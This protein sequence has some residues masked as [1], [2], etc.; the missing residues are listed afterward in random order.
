ME[1]CRLHPTAGRHFVHVFPSDPF[2][3]EIRDCYRSAARR[4]PW[5]SVDDISYWHPDRPEWGDRERVVIF[6][7]ASPG[8]IPRH[9]RAAAVLRYTE[10]VGIPEGL[11]PVQRQLVEQFSA[12]SE[13]FDMLLG[14]TVTVADFWSGK[15]KM[16]AFA[17]IGYEPEI[18]GR[19]DWSTPKIAD[20][21]FRGNLIG[22]RMYIMKK[23][24]KSFLNI[25]WIHSFGLERKFQLDKTLIDLYI[26]HSSDLSFPGMRLWQ[27]I[28]SSAAL[29]MEPRDAWPA[30]AGRHYI[31][32]P[33][34]DPDL[35][36]FFVEKL[37]ELLRD[38]AA[39]RLIAETAHKELSAYTIDRCMEDFVVPATKGLRG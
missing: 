20:F 3:G 9:R 24:Q 12:C 35:F 39:L 21:A 11:N 23:L 26:G 17:P 5:M 15:Y 34:A 38:T 36:G 30:V 2:L 22:R 4:I 7:G 32:I 14:G 31:E 27:G 25:N 13:A 33:E 19:P 16:T 29:V 8:W 6:W 18:L 28:S 10:S 37:R 1:E